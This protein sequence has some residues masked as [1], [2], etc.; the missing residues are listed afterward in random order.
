MIQDMK[1]GPHMDDCPGM[2]FERAGRTIESLEA[3]EV[4]RNLITEMRARIAALEAHMDKF[5]FDVANRYDMEKRGYF[6]QRYP[7]NPLGMASH[8]IWKRDAKVE[9]LLARIAA[10]EAERDAKGVKG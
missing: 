3:S 6:E 8:Y 4:S 7:N 10:L 5:W 1:R 9:D 2:G